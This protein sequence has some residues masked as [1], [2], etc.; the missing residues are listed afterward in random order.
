MCNCINILNGRLANANENTHINRIE[1]TN[2]GEFANRPA[3]KYTVQIMTT[4]LNQK[5]KKRVN[6]VPIFCPFCGKEYAYEEP[7][8]KRV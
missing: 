1:W 5:G 3:K 2:M 6:I 7:K 4:R 8:G